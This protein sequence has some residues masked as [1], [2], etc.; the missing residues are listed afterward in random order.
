MLLRY[1]KILLGILQ[2][3]SEDTEV[4]E[5]TRFGVARSNH[6]SASNISGIAVTPDSEAKHG[7]YFMVD[8]ENS[9]IKTLYPT[10]TSSFFP[11]ARL[12]LFAFL[13]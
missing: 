11:L 3:K 7:I 4:Y 12:G 13:H 1:F 6:Y 10:K 5:Y 8:N 2:S 9:Q